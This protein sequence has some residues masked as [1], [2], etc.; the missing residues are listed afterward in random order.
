M[1]IKNFFLRRPA[2]G[3]EVVSRD[4]VEFVDLSLR[5]GQQSLLATRMSTEQV[6]R[7]LPL[8]LN[9][10]VN[11]LEVWGGATLDSAM[12]YLGENP[13]S[14]LQK[15][16]EMAKPFNA[17]LRALSR[18]QNLFGYDPYPDDIVRD[19]NREAVKAGAS[20]M[21][22][23]DAL[24][25]TPNFK[26]ALDG[27]NEAGGIFDAAVCYTTGSP[28]T[29]DHFVQKCV[30][31]EKMGAHMVSDKDMAGLK[32]PE[33]AWEYYRALKGALSVPVVSHTHCT[34][35]YGHISAVIAML[36]GIDKI[37]TAFLPLA[38]G[39]S[40]PSIEIL[41]LFAEVLGIPTGLDLSEKVLK[42]IHDEMYAVVA[43]VEKKFDLK[44]H[45]SIWPGREKLLPMVEEILGD[46]ARGKIEKALE[47]THAME[48]ACGF[49][50]PNMEVLS[51]Q[52]P[53]GMY[54]NFVNQLAR[55]NKSEY[56]GRALEAVQEIRRKAGWCPLVT[57]TSQIVG[58]KAYFTA[59]GKSVNPVQYFNLIAGYY[60]K[61]PFPIDSDYREEV[62]GFREERE[63]DS[64]DFDRR[65]PLA[66]GTELPLAETTH[67]KLLYYLFPDSSGKSYLEGLRQAEWASTA[68]ERNKRLEEERE[69]KKETLEA[70]ALLNRFADDMDS[71]SER[72]S[73]AVG[74][75][76][77]SY[78]KSPAGDSPEE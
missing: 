33:E 63:Y 24:N 40:H 45:H 8:I 31:L 5:D 67:E 7:L 77:T 11:L 74:N 51:A 28:Y 26:A 46:L 70:N 23:F 76:N 2:P 12:R 9:T 75:G 52:I 4:S 48:R 17:G 21:R 10:G 37:D 43:E 49:P 59:M 50:E 18:G 35:G 36:A 78:L 19:F 30:E 61:T 14:R 53:G 71:L 16:S 64:S 34:P 6:L 41:S 25:Y 29:I 69:K 22:I 39:S 38:G 1:S 65:I 44:I 32:T 54:S 15:M 66:S 27:V 58:V 62:C 42:P 56:L 60:G 13:F 47:V 57:P 73:G 68:R 55:D 20:V 72:L 3:M